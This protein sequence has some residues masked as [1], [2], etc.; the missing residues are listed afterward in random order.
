MFPSSPGEKNERGPASIRLAFFDTIG[1]GLGLFPLGLAFGIL[2]VQAGLDWWWAP[3]FSIAIYAGSME[4]VAIGLIM[5]L[6]PLLQIGLATLLVNFRHVFY[7]LTFPLRSVSGPIAKTYSIYALTDEVY[8]LTAGKRNTDLSSGRILWLQGFCQ[9]YWVLGGVTGGLLGS[10]I[11]GRLAGLEFALTALF[12]VLTI[13]AFRSTRDFVA[14][15][16]ALAASLIA[17]VV[18]S[19]QMMVIAMSLFVAALIVRYF[20]ANRRRSVNPVHGAEARTTGSNGSIAAANEASNE[21][22][23]NNTAGKSATD[24]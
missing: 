10:M 15:L 14:P 17:L 18:S 7:G 3:A 16:I 22:N 21:G 19:D 12:A 9:L 1:V 6:T 20:I 23:R 4:F 8:A 11:P 2:V 13:D 5:S 24:A